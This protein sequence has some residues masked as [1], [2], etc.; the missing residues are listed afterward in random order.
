MVILY[1]RIILTLAATV[2]LGGKKRQIKID[3]V[4][5][6]LDETNIKI[7]YLTRGRTKGTLQKQVNNKWCFGDIP[8]WRILELQQLEVQG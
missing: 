8:D 3:I 2:A 4:K 7:Q 6:I 5:M 1:R